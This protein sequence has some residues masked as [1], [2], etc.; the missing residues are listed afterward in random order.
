MNLLSQLLGLAGLVAL[1]S[2]PFLVLFGQLTVRKLRKNPETKQALGMEFASGWDIFNVAGAL[3]MPRWLNRKLRSTPLSFMYADADLLDKHTT[4]FDTVLAIIF[5]W[6][7]T[8]SSLS[9]IALML[10]DL[11]GVFD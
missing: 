10:L 11:M 9:M 1:V 2:M 3:A 6:L 8:I 5:Y 4:V 7:F